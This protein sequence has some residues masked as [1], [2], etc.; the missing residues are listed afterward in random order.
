DK[1]KRQR[2]W[3]AEDYKLILKREDDPYRLEGFFPCPAAL[4]GV[5]TTSS[6]TPVPEFTLYQDQATELDQIATRLCALVEALKRR[7]VYDASTEG[8]DNQLAQLAFAKD[9]EFVPYR[10]FA[11]L[12]EKGGLKNVFQTEDLAPI[13][14]A[15]EG[16]YKRATFLIQQIY[17]ITGISD[18]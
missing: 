5:K 3:V 2:V 14:T 6:L 16:L 1:S 10:G 18:I 7:G 12:A 8:P 17:E 11:A 13:V 15:I 9:N 4:Y